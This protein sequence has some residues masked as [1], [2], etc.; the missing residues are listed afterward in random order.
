MKKLLSLLLCILL[1]SGCAATYDGPTQTVPRLTEYTVDHYYAFFDT[2]EHHYTDRTLY[3][4]DI[5]GNRVRYMEYRDD[6]LRT[7]TNLKYDDRGNEISR[8]VWDHTGWIPKYKG[9]TEQTYDEQNRQTSYIHYNFWGRQESASWYTYDDE[10][11]T[12]VW[13]NDSGD[14]QTTWFDENGNEIRQVSG[15]YETVY[16]YDDRGNRTGWDSYQ[17]GQPFD[18]YEARYDDLN[19]QIWGGRYDANG[20]LTSQTEYVYD[21][22]QGMKTYHKK[23]GGR[24]VE[25]YHGDGRPHMIEDYDADGKLTMRQRYYYRDIQV[26]AKEE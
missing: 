14:T 15:E 6:E 25:Y 3:A 5:Y 7:V 21:D 22:E 17:N 13:K 19:R 4:Y 1:L 26:P 20:T 24:R 16:H 9:R 10:A 11:R 18:R 8:T 2:E 12:R 23:D